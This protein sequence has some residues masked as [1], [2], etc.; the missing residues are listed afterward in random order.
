MKK[1]K[2]V[3]KEKKQK[4][5]DD[6]KK[7]K[8]VEKKNQNLIQQSMLEKVEGKKGKDKLPDSNKK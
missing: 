3:D 5:N 8:Q 4:I 2:Q 7:I 1:T 6:F